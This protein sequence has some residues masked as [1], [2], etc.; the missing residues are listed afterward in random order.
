MSYDNLTK[1]LAEKYPERFATWLLG[2]PQT[3]VEILKTELSIEPIRADSLTFLKTQSLYPSPR[4]SNP[5]DLGATN[6]LPN[7]RLLGATLSALSIADYSSRHP[8]VTPW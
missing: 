6:K 1:L 4:I 5:L 8:A 2:A 7:A 3:N